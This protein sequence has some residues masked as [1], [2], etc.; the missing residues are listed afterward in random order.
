ML[1]L[2][3]RRVMIIGYSRFDMSRS[4]KTLIVIR[5]DTIISHS[6]YWICK[7]AIFINNNNTNKCSHW[8]CNKY[9]NTCV[10]CGTVICP[11]CLEEPYKCECDNKEECCKLN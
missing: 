10:G 2:L 1:L 7:E 5:G 4:H 3:E 6:I 11:L 9:N 8:A